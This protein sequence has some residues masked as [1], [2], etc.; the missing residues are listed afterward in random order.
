[1]TESEKNLVVKLWAENK[2]ISY[3]VSLL[4][5]RPYVAKTQIKKMI[6]EGALQN[7]V[8]RSKAESVKM[9]ASVY[10]NKTSNIYEIAKELNL[11]VGYVSEL[12]RLA[13][14]KRKRP[15]KNYKK[16]KKTELND[17]SNKSQ[18]IILELKS[19]KSARLIA[20]EKDVSVQWVH[21]TK[22][23]YKHIFDKL[24]ETEA[25]EYGTRVWFYE[26][27]YKSNL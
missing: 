6:E 3:I 22:K 11:T 12:V 4:P 23:R 1:M 21:E 15:P 8:F 9:V 14:I 16:R 26:V 13:G 25:Q 2:S 10:K 5:Y 17:L 18:E 27:C 19:G 24:T 7:R 20:K